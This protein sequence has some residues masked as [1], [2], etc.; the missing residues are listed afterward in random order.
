MSTGLLVVAEVEEDVGDWLGNKKHPI[1]D[2]LEQG[3]ESSSCLILIAFKPS[4]NCHDRCSE[5]CCNCT[6]MSRCDI[7]M[8]FVMTRLSLSSS[9]AAIASI[10]MPTTGDF[11]CFLL[12]SVLLTSG[13]VLYRFDTIILM[14]VAVVVTCVRRGIRPCGKGDWCNFG[15]NAILMW[16][17]PVS[18]DQKQSCIVRHATILEC[19]TV[20]TKLLGRHQGRV[21]KLANE[22]ASPHV[23]YTCCEDGLVQHFD[24]RTGEATELFTCQSVQGRIFTPVVSLNAIAI[25]L[26]NTK[27]F[28][29]AGSDEFTRLYDIRK[30]RYDAS[31]GF[32]K[33]VD[34]FCL[35][36]L[37]GDE[38]VRITGLAFLDQSELLVSYSEEFIYLFSKDMGWGSPQ[39]F[40]GHQNCLTVKGVS[41]FGVTE[42]V[43][44]GSDCGRMFIWKKKDAKLVRVMEEDREVVNCIK[45]HPH[46]HMLASCGI[47]KDIKIWTPTALE[48]ASPPTNINRLR[49]NTNYLRVSPRDMAL[50]LLAKR[51]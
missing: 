25:D 17:L 39:V 32:G 46:T 44:S 7:V 42:Y 22:P 40:K 14:A 26:V 51:S 11:Q 21:Y 36:H 20:E 41:F 47:D 38:N 29:I 35:E 33:P 28:V 12:S 34:H 8:F 9:R 50:E 27:L 19:G 3:Q 10:N 18:L 6:S 49:S 45:P 43:T 2:G 24:L 37:L 15:K 30:Y 16:L 23:F 48:K 1:H 4:S 31:T 13:V 5:I